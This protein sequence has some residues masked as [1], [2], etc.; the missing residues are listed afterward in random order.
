MAKAHRNYY[1]NLK[2]FTLQAIEQHPN[3]N[4]QRPSKFAQDIVNYFMEG[5][6]DRV[7]RK[8][9]R[10]KGTPLARKKYS[11]YTFKLETL[12]KRRKEKKSKLPEKLPY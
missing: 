12:E 6:P 8:W 7:Q 1:K 11:E 4:G 3:L 10:I 2:Q 5:V 9:M